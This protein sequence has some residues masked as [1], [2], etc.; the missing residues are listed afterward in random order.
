MTMIAGSGATHSRS[1]DVFDRACPSR[2]VLDDVSGRWGLLALAALAQGTLRFNELRRRVD[3]VS[4]KMLSQALRS[5]ER[6]GLVLRTAYPVIPP[7]VDY[8]LT[9]LGESAAS[10]V[11]GVLEWLESHTDQVLASRRH[12]DRAAR[13]AGRARTPTPH[14]RQPHELSRPIES[15]AGR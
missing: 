11:C 10:V 14:I 12:H 5:L 13:R 2:D 3:G 4:E 6:D 15:P 9:P 1:Y 7:R 8:Q